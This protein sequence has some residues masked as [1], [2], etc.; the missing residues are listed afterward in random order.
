[1]TYFYAEN[2]FARRNLK[3]YSLII[4]NL[5]TG[6]E[7]GDKAFQDAYNN[8]KLGAYTQIDR[9]RLMDLRDY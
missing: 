4:T 8:K 2:M 7:A 3:T 6:D 9:D 1:M 5:V